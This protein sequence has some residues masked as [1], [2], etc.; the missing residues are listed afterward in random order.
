VLEHFDSAQ[1]PDVIPMFVY[2][3]LRPGCDLHY[4]IQDA[5]VDHEPATVVGYE[6]RDL[7][8][9]PLM[10]RAEGQVVYGELLWVKRSHPST[11]RTIG[12]E[13]ASGYT[14]DMPEVEGDMV[15]LPIPALCFV[16][17]RIDA[18]ASLP[19]VPENDWIAR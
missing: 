2:G 18:A 17:D 8:P 6:L 10:I 7:G 15:N 13:L 9:Y 11:M 5:V 4:W 14:L 3:T 12:M 16:W 19:R 1:G